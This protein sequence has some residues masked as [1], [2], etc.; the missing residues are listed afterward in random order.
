M[1]GAERLGGGTRGLDGDVTAETLPSAFEQNL[2]AMP[3][4]AEGARVG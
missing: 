4:P 1:L 2:L 3:G